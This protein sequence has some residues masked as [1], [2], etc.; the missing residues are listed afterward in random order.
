M[1]DLEK[2]FAYVK[3]HLK[4]HSLIKNAMTDVFGY[5]SWLYNLHGIPLF[6][7]WVVDAWDHPVRLGVYEG[8]TGTDHSIYDTFEL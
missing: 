5:S 4:A 1:G 6:W 8:T 3:T 2:N 7:R